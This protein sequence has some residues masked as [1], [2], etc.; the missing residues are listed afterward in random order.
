MKTRWMTMALLGAMAVPVMAQEQP[1]NEAPPPPRREDGRGEGRGGDDRPSPPGPRDDR[2]RRPDGP[3]RMDGPGRPDG[4]RPN[5]PPNQPV[6]PMGEAG[7]PQVR[8]MM[9]YL[10]LVEQYKHLTQD[11]TAAGVAAVVTAGD[12]LRPQGAKGAIEY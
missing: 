8:A 12:I 7:S 9:G 5:G 1:G 6:P 3:R 2:E 11:S 4:M 10:Q